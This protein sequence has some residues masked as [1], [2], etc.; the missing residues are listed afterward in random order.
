VQHVGG[1]LDISLQGYRRNAIRVCYFAE[2]E[3]LDD[4]C[5]GIDVK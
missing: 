4:L 5:L 2:L 3:G 1:G